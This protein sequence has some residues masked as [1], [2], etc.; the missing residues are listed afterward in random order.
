MREPIPRDK[1]KIII[2]GGGPNRIGQ[3]IEF[4][5]C[6][7][8]AAFSLSAQGYRD[9]HGQLQSR[10]R[11]D[12][13]RHLRPALFRA[14]D[15]RRRAGDRRQGTGKG[16]AGRRDRA[17]RRPD[18]AQARQHAGRGRRADPRHQRRRHRPR[19]RPQALPGAAQRARPQAAAQRHRDDGR[20]N[21]RG[22]ARHRLSGDPAPVL[23]AGRA[24][25]GGGGRRSAA[26]GNRCSR[27]SCSASRATIRC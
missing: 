22:G 26:E 5:Y 13:L 11:L 23:C 14:A 12:R 15:R 10:D 9:H 7:C 4:D 25:H 18:A 21:H 27:A 16:H 24:R 2:L 20:G 17:V 3:G 6:C 1:K 19:R 8:H